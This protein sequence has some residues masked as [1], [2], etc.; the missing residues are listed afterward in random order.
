MSKKIWSE[1]TVGDGIERTV[2]EMQKI[3]ALDAVPM[4]R[5]TENHARRADV[6]VALS[7]VSKTH[8]S[9]S[10][11]TLT[12]FCQYGGKVY[13][14]GWTAIVDGNTRVYFWK[15]NMS[16]YVPSHVN[17]TIYKCANMEEVSELYHQFDS[18]TAVETNAQKVHGIFT[19]RHNFYPISHKFKSGQIQ[20]A[21]HFAAH[22]VDPIKFDNSSVKIEN[23]ELQV[24]LFIEEI[25]ALDALINNDERWKTPLVAGALVALKYYGTDNERLLECLALIES[26][27]INTTSLHR[28]GVTHIN[29][30]WH[31]NLK[32][33]EK[34]TSWNSVW[35]LNNTVNF[36]LYWIEKY[37]LD[38]KTTKLG[39]KWER[40]ADNWFR[41]GLP[42]LDA[43]F[44]I[45]NSTKVVEHA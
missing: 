37:M 33:K 11:V 4:Q 38:I 15:N 41:N 1:F 10:L 31:T 36:V 16:D 17:V 13:P 9:I 14:A 22:L 34:T 24:S 20:S 29:F 3:F 28:D 44:N 6:K 45:N 5:D 25:K 35:G 18:K 42:G 32:F 12:K 19:G 39:T 30:E 2:F 8:M 7:V 23:L 43:F 40:T 26:R 27:V 21:L